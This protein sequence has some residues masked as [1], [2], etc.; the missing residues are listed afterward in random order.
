MR[1]ARKHTELD[2]LVALRSALH[3]ARNALGDAYP[4]A[5]DQKTA[6]IASDVDRLESEVVEILAVLERH[7]PTVDLSGRCQGCP[8]C[9]S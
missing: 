4:L 5:C 9:V 1:R 7:W 2:V 6:K 8:R 3:T